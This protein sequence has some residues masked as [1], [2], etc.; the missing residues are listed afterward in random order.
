MAKWK[1]AIVALVLVAAVGCG[2]P[3][4]ILRAH[5]AEARAIA[6]YEKNANARFEAMAQTDY[7][8]W[9]A[10]E[11]AKFRR[12]LEDAAGEDGEVPVELVF[13]LLE[14][15][16]EVETRALKHKQEIL[17]AWYA[18]AQDIKTAKALHEAIGNWLGVL[19]PFAGE[20]SDVAGER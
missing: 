20:M 10:N 13:S 8:R 7:E 2:I 12:K 14:D 6:Q 3:G 15:W 5:E 1:I 16:A 17:D 9:R 4:E 19:V 18:D 11:W